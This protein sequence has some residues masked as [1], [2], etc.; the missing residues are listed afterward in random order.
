MVWLRRIKVKS[1]VVRQEM[2]SVGDRALLVELVCR[3]E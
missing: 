3:L 1:V 2:M